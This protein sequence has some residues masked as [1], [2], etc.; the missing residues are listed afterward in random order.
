MTRRVLVLGSTG[1]I[2]EQA[3]EIIREHPDDFTL[4]GLAVG[5]NAARARQQAAEFGLSDD[6]VA[7]G[8]AAAVTLIEREPADVILNGIAGAAGLLPTLAALRTEAKLALANKESLIIGGA[9]VLSGASPG[10]LVAVDSEHSA[11]A[12]CLRSGKPHEVKQLWL[13]ASGG[14]FRG[15]SRD[16]LRAVTPSQAL[17]HPTWNMGPLVTTNS[18]TLVNKGLELIEAHL[19]FDV[20]ISDIRVVVHPQSI[21]HSMVEFH[22]GSIIAQASPPNMKLPIAL[23]LSWPE[24]IADAAPPLDFSRASE[25]QFEP[26]DEQVFDAVSLAREAAIAGGS[27][28]AAYNAANEAAVAAFHGSRISFL[29]ITEI[30]ASVLD[31]HLPQQTNLDGILEADRAARAQAQSEIQSGR[32]GLKGK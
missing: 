3:L 24:R 30:I 2:G 15:F 28:P 22:D 5:S 21:V 4:V 19:L 7:V 18:A 8:V 20:A 25:W 27:Y 11:L 9:L 6:Q 12:Q 26:L 29:A 16:Q 14:P 1:S 17:R 31:S 13:T 23:G 32:F 10:Q